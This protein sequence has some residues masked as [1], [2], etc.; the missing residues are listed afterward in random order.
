MKDFVLQ[1]KSPAGFN[2]PLV[3]E[4]CCTQGE[5]FCSPFVLSMEW[6]INSKFAEFAVISEILNSDL[7]NR[8]ES[9]FVSQRPVFEAG[10]FG[11]D[12]WHFCQ[13]SLVLASG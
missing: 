4:F 13:L 3:Y 7:T 9:G 6:L 12:P 1:A 11:N 8:L 2:A 10:W 5:R